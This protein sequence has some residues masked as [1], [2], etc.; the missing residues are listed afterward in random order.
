L[1]EKGEKKLEFKMPFLGWW[2]GKIIHKRLKIN[3]IEWNLL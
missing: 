3:I 2:K 1:E